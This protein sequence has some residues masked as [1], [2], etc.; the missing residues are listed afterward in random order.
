V[1]E[2]LSKRCCACIDLNFLCYDSFTGQGQL[3]WVGIC[4]KDNFGWRFS[5]VSMASI[6]LGLW[7]YGVEMSDAGETI[8]REESQ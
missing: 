2:I 4:L 5:L 1:P 7:F 8:E 3:V 6:N